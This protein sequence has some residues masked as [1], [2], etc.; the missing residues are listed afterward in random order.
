MKRESSVDRTRC[1]RLCFLLASLLLVLLCASPGLAAFGEDE[2]KPKPEFTREGE[3]ITAKLIP[4]G[5]RVN[6][7]ITFTVRGGPLQ[8]VEAMDF[9]EAE[10]PDVDRKDFR[11][12]LFV[13]KIGR[14]A[15]GAEVDVA[16]ASNYFT[17]S[18][19]FWVFN[20]K[21]AKAWAKVEAG[22]TS[23]GEKVEEL[24][25]RVRDG[26]PLDSDGEANGEIVLICAP[27]DTFWGYAIGTLV[28]R[29]FGVFLV[30]MVLQ[31][32]M[33]VASRIFRLLET[34]ATR[35]RAAAAAAVAAPAS[36]SEGAPQPV[37]AGVAA[38]IALALQLHLAAGRHGEVLQLERGE[39]PAWTLHGRERIMGERFLVFDRSHHAD[40]TR[41]SR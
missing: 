1:R 34:R 37:D 21:G 9:S 22:H 38:A 41:L 17:G 35:A 18:T 28:I 29:F 13:V 6:V 4:R 26:G 10:R 3:Q 15:P 32:G 25:A 30:L 23:L 39:V 16:M 31:I 12:G 19:E 20:P 27:M 40:P 5:K 8:S 2:E 33:Q 36:A 14:V 11:S 7:Q 24:R